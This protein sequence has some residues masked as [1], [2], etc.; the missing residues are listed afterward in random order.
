MTIAALRAQRQH[1]VHGPVVAREVED[2][3]AADLRRDPFVA[4][5]LP[6]IEEIARMLAIEGS[7]ELAAVEVFEG[8]ERQLQIG[9]QR[10]L[11]FRA[12]RAGSDRMHRSAHHEVDFDR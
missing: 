11:R 3:A 5:E 4:E 2:E 1:F 7:D 10:F 9:L 6:D 8:D 12:E